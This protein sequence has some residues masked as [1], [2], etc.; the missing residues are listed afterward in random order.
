MDIGKNENNVTAPR[1]IA[2]GAKLFSEHTSH[3]VSN[4][5]LA[6]EAGVNHA[7][8][9]YYFGSRDGLCEAIFGH[10]LT[11]WKAIMLPLVEQI[12]NRIGESS[13]PED[14]AR[15]AH[16]LVRGMI[17]AIT[18]KEGTRFLRV[19][20]NEGL[21]KPRELNR[22][23]FQDVIRPFHAV[24]TRLAAAARGLPPEDM[25]SMVLGQAIVAQCMTFFRGRVLLR[26][27]LD[28]KALDQGRAEQIADI[29]S[30][31]VCASLG[32]PD[33]IRQ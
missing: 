21:I 10:C 5:A 8:I 25:E 28:L 14:L 27:R 24:A 18:G 12:D 30:R 22:R 26:P 17:S 3:E 13:D 33:N 15:I 23:M 32:L 19:L 31:S 2:A 6:K 7:A 1:L 20:F 11:Q 9:N 4:R 16:D 29:L